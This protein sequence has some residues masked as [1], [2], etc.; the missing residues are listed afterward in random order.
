[1][2]WILEEIC[3]H[4]DSRGKPSAIVGGKNSHMSKII[5]I[6]MKTKI[7]PVEKNINELPP[8]LTTQISIYG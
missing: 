1:M 2:P 7:I 5:Q 4:S 3:S 6:L 8:T